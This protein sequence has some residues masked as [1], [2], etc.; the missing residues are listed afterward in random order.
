MKAGILWMPFFLPLFAAWF[1]LSM[2][3]WKVFFPFLLNFTFNKIFC[4]LVTLLLSLGYFIWG[5]N[6]ISNLVI[7]VASSDLVMIKLWQEW[8]VEETSLAVPSLLPFSPPFFLSPL[9]LQFKDPLL[10]NWT[11]HWDVLFLQCDAKTVLYFG[12]TWSSLWQR[13]CFHSEPAMYYIL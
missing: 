1:F 10:Q 4:C 3:I 6:V 8:V 2:Y 5:C 12:G 11:L 7:L 13:Q 9:P